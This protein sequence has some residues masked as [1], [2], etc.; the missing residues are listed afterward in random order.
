VEIVVFLLTQV[1]FFDGIGWKE[2]WPFGMERLSYSMAPFCIANH[3][4]L[5]AVMTT[6]R[7]EII[8]EGSDDGETWRAYEFK[9]KPGDVA[10]RP[11]FAAPHQPRLDW[12]M[13]F[14]ALGHYQQH[15]WFGS[16]CKRLLQ[17]EPKV[18]TLL[19]YNPFPGKP[20]RFVRGVLYDYRFT[21]SASRRATGH[22]W[23][24]E[25]KG[26]YSPVMSLPKDR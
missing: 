4:G 16:L 12:Q 21:D 2:T 14:A 15:P 10:R 1:A 18:L 3:Y 5:F 9:Y 20:P 25:S 26:L 24:R 8:L 22:W 23:R 7:P 19:A 17:G 11:P 6:E 13:W